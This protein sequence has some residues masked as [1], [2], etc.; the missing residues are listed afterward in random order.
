MRRP[1]GAGGSGAGAGGFVS[2]FKDVPTGSGPGPPS[3]FLL[4]MTI[5]ITT[6]TITTKPSSPSHDR[7]TLSVKIPFHHGVGEPS[8]G[9]ATSTLSPLLRVTATVFMDISSQCRCPSTRQPLQS[10]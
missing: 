2:V 7:I 5:M 1:V 6:P 8:G 9:G 10:N 3:G 4:T